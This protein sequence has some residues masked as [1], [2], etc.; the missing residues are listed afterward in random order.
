V[1]A[2][3]NNG[4]RIVTRQPRPSYNGRHTLTP[5]MLSV[6]TNNDIIIFGT[7]EEERTGLYETKSLDGT[8]PDTK[9]G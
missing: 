7:H 5:R 3:F 9:N 6:I 1:D 2:I 4:S 8:K